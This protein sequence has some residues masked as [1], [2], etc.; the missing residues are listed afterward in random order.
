MAD[1]K[2]Y[3]VETF[4][5]GKSKKPYWRI[6]HKNQNILCTSEKYQNEDD[7]IKIAKNVSRSSG[8]KFINMIK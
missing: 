1:N 5:G 2:D 7:C 8:F 4:I 3:T 6:R